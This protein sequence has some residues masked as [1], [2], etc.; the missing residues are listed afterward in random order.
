MNIS[1]CPCDRMEHPLGLCPLLGN[2]SLKV[3]VYYVQIAHQSSLQD[4]GLPLPG[5][6]PL[7][8]LIWEALTPIMLRNPWQC[9]IILCLL[10]G[11]FSSYWVALFSLDALCARQH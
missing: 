7:L 1:K 8:Y 5:G 11:P 10:L 3:E 9:H 2:P 6:L 4:G